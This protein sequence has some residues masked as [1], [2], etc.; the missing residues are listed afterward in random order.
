M[1]RVQKHRAITLERLEL[2]ETGKCYD[3]A[4]GIHILGSLYRG[5]QPIQNIQVIKDT[6]RIKFQEMVAIHDDYIETKIGEQ[7][8]PT[9][10]THWFR[11]S[12]LI[13]QEWQG[14]EIHFIWDSDSEA[15]LWSENGTILQV[16]LYYKFERIRINLV[17]KIKGVKWVWWRRQTF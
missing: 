13:P 7:F 16:N 6:G 8:G 2:L 15:T 3:K 11:V 10:S 1:W 12:F 17:L 14:N 4:D 5:Y 9:W